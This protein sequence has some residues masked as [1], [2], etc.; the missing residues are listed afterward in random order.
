MAANNADMEAAVTATSPDNY[1]PMY[2]GTGT[3]TDIAGSLGTSMVGTLTWDAETHFGDTALQWNDTTTDYIDL[4]TA[5]TDSGDFTWQVSAR[6][7]S[8]SDVFLLVKNTDDGYFG[9]TDSTH[10]LVQQLYPS[11]FGL[12]FTLSTDTWYLIHVVRESGVV[13]VYIDADPSSTIS[14]GYTNNVKNFGRYHS[15]GYSMYGQMNHIAHWT[16]ALDPTTEIAPLY[17][18]WVNGGS[19]GDSIPGSPST[20]TV[21]PVAQGTAGA[22]SRTLAPATAT[23]T[24]VALG[25]IDGGG[26]PA[27]DNWADAIELVGSSG[28]TSGTMVGATTE[29]GDSIAFFDNVWYYYVPDVGEDGYILSVDFTGS[30]Y[31]MYVVFATSPDATPTVESLEYDSDGGPGVATYVLQYGTTVWL[32]VEPYNGPPDIGAFD[33]AWDTSPPPPPPANDDFADAILLTG[34]SGSE[35]GTTLDATE[36]VGEPSLASNNSIWWY[37]TAP[38]NG[39]A[40][41]DFGDSD[42][43]DTYVGVYTS[44]AATPTVATLLEVVKD[45]D[46]GVNDT[47][48]FS[49]SA[50]SGTTYYIMVDTYG[51][52]TVLFDWNFVAYTAVDSTYFDYVALM[53]SEDP[54]M[55]AQLDEGVI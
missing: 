24:G 8:L 53:R 47:S 51:T 35:S 13:T 1:W 41:F 16:R 22:A 39:R 12:P 46:S 34:V 50:A 6:F 55:Y 21:T 42:P 20:I 26:A 52:G 14:S 38:A 30:E 45:N 36:E 37:W 3:P 25:V 7:D 18:V 4:A 49:F 31:D 29:V 17:D 23:V 10:A 44:N 54:F 15:S 48:L 9:I 43:E 40:S 32:S 19:G 33:L 2:E 11:Y 5:L 27:N 28:T